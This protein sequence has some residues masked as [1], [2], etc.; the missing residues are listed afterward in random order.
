LLTAA[1]VGQPTEYFN[2]LYASKFS[3]RLGLSG[4][5]LKE[6]QLGAYIEALRRERSATNVFATKLQYNQFD[7]YL[8]NRH[9]RALF[10]HA[11][12]VH[13]FRPDAAEQFASLREALE[14]GIWDSKRRILPRRSPHRQERVDEAIADMDGLL[15]ED[16]GFR[17]LFILLGIRP[18]FVTMD[19]LVSA[20]REVTERIAGSMSVAI[21]G[22]SLQ[23]AIAKNP[24]YPHQEARESA[25]AGLAAA[26]QALAFLQ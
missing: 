9:G 19:E 22:P 12:V 15:A 2:P 24:P 17:K 6:D 7:K 21:D 26:F 18:L 23:R 4:N 3:I 20:P 8:R 25:M 5:P 1:G 11:V 16:T 14:T 13:L 10:E